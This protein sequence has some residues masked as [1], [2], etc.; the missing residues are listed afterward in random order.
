MYIDPDMVVFDRLDPVHEALQDHAIVV[1]PASMTPVLDGH[2]PDDIEFLR[3]GV[4]NLGFVAVS[5]T[6]EARRFLR[7]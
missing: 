2:R 1:T 5:R 7:W 3:V 4:F 6:D